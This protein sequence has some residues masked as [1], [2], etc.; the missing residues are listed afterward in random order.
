MLCRGEQG[1]RWSQALETKRWEVQR[2]G[3]ELEWHRIHV[4]LL[5]ASC[6]SMFEEGFL[7]RRKKLTWLLSTN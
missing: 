5:P 6:V 2:Q 4:N 7:G 3:I 1:W